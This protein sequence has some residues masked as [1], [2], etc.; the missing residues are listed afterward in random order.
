[1]P[2]PKGA[3]FEGYVACYRAGHKC[4]PKVA[5]VTEDDTHVTTSWRC[6]CCGDHGS[7]SCVPKEWGDIGLELGNVEVVL[8]D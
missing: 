6:P 3:P 4:P 1:M 7:T 2:Q 8:G 5:T